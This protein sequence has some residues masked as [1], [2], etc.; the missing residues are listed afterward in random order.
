MANQLPPVA[1]EEFEGPFDLLIELAQQSKIDLS[2][3]SLTKMTEAY[4]AM[5]ERGRFAPSLIAD[6]LVVAATLLLLKV[7]HVLPERESEEEVAIAQLSDRVRIYQLY[8]EQARLMLAAWRPWL[9]PSP[10]ALTVSYPLPFPSITAPELART[11]ADVCGRVALPRS[12]TRHL[13]ERGRTLPECLAF[14]QKRLS[15][16]STI[17]LQEEL[18]N[19]SRDTLAVSFLAVLELARQRHVVLHQSHLFS[20]L[21]IRARQFSP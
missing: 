3:I 20:P 2:T 21:Q 10:A 15:Q 18:L 7:R 14:L 1:I 19:E 12:S 5:V 4:L 6:F 13:R 11:M 8:R 16:T 17:V 9:L